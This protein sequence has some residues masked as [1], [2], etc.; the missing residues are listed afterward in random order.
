LRQS[1]RASP[2]IGAVTNVLSHKDN[3][4]FWYAVSW[5]DSRGELQYLVLEYLARTKGWLNVVPGVDHGS[6]L[7]VQVSPAGHDHLESLRHGG[8][9]LDSGFCAMWFS[10]EVKAIWTDAIEPSI[11][12]AGYKAIRI[13]G[14]EHNNKIDDEILSNIR[15]SRFV[16]ADFTGERGGVYFEA[17]FA[18]GLGRHVIWTVREDA[19]NKV[20]FDNRQYNFIVWKK[21]DLGEFAKRLRLRIEAT[22]GSGPL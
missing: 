11:K 9:D 6:H 1:Q 8:D 18:L 13:D 16:V 5:S 19:L 3:P 20:H 4:I 17:G 7:D 14:V 21:D 10:D 15:R 2:D 12:A 22:V